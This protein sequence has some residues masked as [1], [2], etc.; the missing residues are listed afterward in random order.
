MRRWRAIST[1]PANCCGWRSTRRA[2]TRRRSSA[3]ARADCSPRSA[4]R[5]TSPAAVAGRAWRARVFPGHPYALPTNGTAESLAAVDARRPA[6]GWRKRLVTRGA[7]QIAVVG[8]IDEARAAKLIDDVFADLPAVDG[9]IAPQPAPFVG[10]G[11]VEVVD[12]DVPQSTIRFGRPAPG[13]DDDDHMASVVLAHVLG[14]GTGLTSRLFREVREKR[15]LAYSASAAVA[16]FEQTSYLHGGTTTK[17]ERAYESLEVI[18]NEILDLAHGGISE[19]ELEKG[20]RYLVG[21]Y[22]LRFD[23]STKIAGQLVHIQLEGH[24]PDWLTERNAR[25]SAVTM[26]DARRAGERCS[27]TARCRW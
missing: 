18:G 19:D 26:A 4:T 11:G 1:A 20:K 2:S 5:P 27:A 9:R 14:G 24:G 22:P 16:A 17:N 3:G 15:G 6:E 7:L 25:I 10:L 13:R 12:L 23:T 21:S 8:A